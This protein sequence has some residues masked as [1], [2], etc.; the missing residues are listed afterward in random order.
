MNQPIQRERLL[1]V[2][3]LAVELRVKESWIYGRV[4]CRGIPHLRVGKYLRFRLTDVMAQ[5]EAE[6]VA[7]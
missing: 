3:E 2:P 1:T 7:A 5:L 6:K 4:A